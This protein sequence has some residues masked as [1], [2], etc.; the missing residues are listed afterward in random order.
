MNKIETPFLRRVLEQRFV[1]LTET[2]K[3]KDYQRR[4]SITHKI[5]S[6]ETKRTRH[7]QSHSN[8]IV[9]RFDC[10]RECRE[11]QKV[12]GKTSDTQHKH[13]CPERNLD[14][15]TTSFSDGNYKIDFWLRNGKFRWNGWN[16]TTNHKDLVG[17]E[18]G[19]HGEKVLESFRLT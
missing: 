19:E 18:T 14:R 16:Q 11:S 7:Q 8:P 15:Y 6:I 5:S 13:R 9:K 12:A 1:E 4:R 3:I 10:D 17:K 2:K